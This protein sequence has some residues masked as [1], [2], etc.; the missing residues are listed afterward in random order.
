MCYNE[1]LLTSDSLLNK[2]VFDPINDTNKFTHEHF[3]KFVK[4]LTKDELRYLCIYATGAPYCPHQSIK[5]H[6]KGTRGFYSSTCLL[7]MDIPVTIFSNQEEFNLAFKAALNG[8]RV[9]TVV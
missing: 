6:Y 5:V 1:K 3:I 4:S 8:K 2:C 7:T 9:F